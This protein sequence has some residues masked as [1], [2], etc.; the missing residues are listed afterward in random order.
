MESRGPIGMEQGLDMYAGDRIGLRIVAD[1]G[2]WFI[3]VQPGKVKTN[4]GGSTGWFSLEAWSSCLGAPVL[5]HDGRPTDADGEWQAVLENSWQLE[6]Q[7][8]YLREH[9]DQIDAA[10]SPE[11]VEAT[12]A[13]L[14]AIQRKLSAFPPKRA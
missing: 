1:R 6:P 7:L 10:C 5:F 14:L 4:V 12:L 3:D 8:K 2:Q 13:C 11:I 9:L